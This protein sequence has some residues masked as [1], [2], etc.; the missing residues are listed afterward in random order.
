MRKFFVV[1]L[2]VLPFLIFADPSAKPVS[3]GMQPSSAQAGATI[4]VRVDY[5]TS[6]ISSLDGPAYSTNNLDKVL[7]YFYSTNPPNG[8][9][10]LGYQG[11]NINNWWYSGVGSNKY[12][13]FDFTLPEYSGAASF[14]L[15]LC[16]Y[17]EDE[18]GDPALGSKRTS[19]ISQSR[20]TKAE[21]NPP[22]G[23]YEYV[24]YQSPTPIELSSF[25]ASFEGHPKLYWTTQTESNNQ[26]WNIYRAESDEGVLNQDWQ[27][28]NSELIQGQGTS[29]QPTD[30]DYTDLNDVEIGSTYYYVLECVDLSG[31]A[32]L[33]GPI[34]LTI[35][36]LN[37][38]PIPPNTKINVLRNTPNPFYQSENTI[39]YYQMKE[40]TQSCTGDLSIY[41]MKGEKIKT[42]FS[43]EIGSGLQSQIWDGKDNSG[44]KVTTGIYFYKLNTNIGS[45]TRKMILLR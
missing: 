25:T 30:Y 31:V 17:W 3:I 40:I 45:Y 16:L 22:G 44:N 11:V 14:Q 28:I 39:I 7:I 24:E 5:N 29:S 35:P 1:F 18:F 42:I 2:F 27:A 6:D 9:S 4:D 8:D 19:Y 32:Q 43:G 15:M 41:N 10:Y 23:W 34:Q 26:G 37:N 21:S 38:D 36:E 13:T 20:Y 33:Y 12:C